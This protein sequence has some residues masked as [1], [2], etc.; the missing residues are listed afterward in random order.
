MGLEDLLELTKDGSPPTTRRGSILERPTTGRNLTP[1]KTWSA[2][3]NSDGASLLKFAETKHAAECTKLL[4][5][6]VRS[7]DP[8]NASFKPPPRLATCVVSQEQK[9]EAF[10][11]L[12]KDD[13]EGLEKFLEP[14]GP[15]NWE[16]WKNKG[17]KSLLDMAEERSKENCHSF[18]LKALDRV[19]S[20]AAEDIDEGDAVW[21]FEPGELQPH[22]ATC[23]S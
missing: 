6:A 22:K 2:W 9:T 3:K 11:L 8:D 1:Y 23:V 20:L 15:E 12:M 10:K 13:V 17:G 18:L 21:V 4:T 14:Y 16:Q 19:S 5:A 7:I